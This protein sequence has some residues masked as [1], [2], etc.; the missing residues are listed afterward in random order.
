MEKLIAN[1]GRLVSWIMMLLA[2]CVVDCY[3][4]SLEITALEASK[5]TGLFWGSGL[6]GRNSVE[7][8]GA[9]TC[10]KILQ[11]FTPIL[12]SWPGMAEGFLGWFYISGSRGKE[13]SQ[14]PK[15]LLEPGYKPTSPTRKQIC[16]W[17]SSGG[18]PCRTRTSAKASWGGSCSLRSKASFCLH[19]VPLPIF[20]DQ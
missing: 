11:S 16:F 7:W 1:V 15:S 10:Q 5:E 3:Q 8:G 14:A 6:M 19:K 18:R 20:P 17:L 12:G 9:N 4:K 13:A 2:F